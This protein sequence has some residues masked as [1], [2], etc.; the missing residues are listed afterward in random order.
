MKLVH[1]HCHS[2]CFCL[3][4]ESDER[5]DELLITDLR[6]ALPSDAW[7]DASCHAHD[8]RPLVQPA[9]KWQILDYRSA[10]YS[11]SLLR[12]S[13]ADACELR[14]PLGC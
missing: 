11:G 3:R 13:H 7:T 5:V 12:T 8:L 9:G 6:C 2:C 1:G 14:I 4:Y 10:L